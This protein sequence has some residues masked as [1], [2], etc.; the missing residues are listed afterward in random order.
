M[1]TVPWDQVRDVVDAVLALEPGQ[2]A[3]FLSQ[4]CPEPAVKR[5]VE[6]LLAAYDEGGDLLDQPAVFSPANPLIESE[7]K[8]WVG[9][10]ISSYQIVAEIGEGGMGAVYRAIRADDQY[11]QQVAIKVVRSGFPSSFTLGRFRA[12]RQILA[13]LEHPN[14]ARLLDGGAEAGLPYLV[15]EL[16]EG[17][18]IDQYCDRHRLTVTERLRLFRMACEAVQY[19]H[20]RLVVHRDLKPGNILVTSEGAPKL[21][22]FGIAKILDPGSFPH[23][24]DPTMTAMRMLTP[25]YASP[26]QVRGET[27]T[28]ATDVYS[29]GVVLYVLLTGRGPYPLKSHAPHELAQ[30][31]CDAEPEKPST[32]IGGG[33]N[34]EDDSE[35]GRPRLETASSRRGESPNRLRRRLRGDLDNIVLMALRKEPERRYA[36][37]EQLSEDI[38]RHLEGLP[39]IAYQDTLGYRSGKFIKRN[40]LAVTAVIVVVLS[41]V[42]G[43]AATVHEARVARAQRARAEQR[44]NDVRSL[45]NSLMFEIH[46]SIKD[47]PGSTPARK[48]LVE[49]ALRYLNSLA[50]ESGGDPALQRE[51]ANAYE[52]VGNV[53]GDPNGSNLGDTAGALD[54]FTKALRIRR[55]IAYAKS[56]DGR[57][58]LIALAA[59]YRE[60]CGVNARY[61]GNIGAGLDYC[62]KALD[63]AGK[64]NRIYSGNLRVTAELARVYDTIGRIY[65]EGSTV[66]N[67]GDS[68]AALENHRQELDLVRQLAKASP[69][70]PS[71]RQWLGTVDILTADDLFETGAV[72]EALPLYQEAMQTFE[73]L[74][75]DT[76]NPGYRRSLALSYQRMGDMLLTNGRYPQSLKYYRQ[77]LNEA[78]IIATADP[79]NMLFRRTLAASYATMGHAFW[80]A[81]QVSEGVASLRQGLVEIGE[82]TDKDSQTRNLEALIKIWVAGALERSGDLAGALNNYRQGRASFEAEWAADPRDVEGRLMLAGTQDRIAR[83]CIRQRRFGEALTEYRKALTL[84]EPLSTGTP[85]NLEALYTVVN[86][87]YGMGEVSIALAREAGVRN[88]KIKYWTEAR[89]WYQKSLDASGRIPN[90]RPITPNE[91]DSRS[92]KEIVARLSLCQSALARRS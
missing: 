47:L 86:V 41:L 49:R 64:L 44:F 63:L 69:S 74:A 8:S 28:T 52:R 25:E 73:L 78:T 72:P 40:K 24:P 39:I 71:L 92:P 58:D 68:Y 4:A 33:E 11:R 61:L 2:R 81:G 56:D 50:Q 70:D 80:R 31:I 55:N 7:A 37:V 30:A 82:P 91:F 48:L 75:R 14:I 9:R 35:K 3:D 60:I 16:V 6:S 77:Q 17:E 45:A 5:Y 38:R 85:P 89:T 12:E 46:D 62:G 53:Q 51:L 67:A 27:I 13:G 79:K 43:M 32:A 23:A 83:I 88:R 36:S 22:D 76:G 90:W 26:E 87:Y 21:L 15:M 57:D 1:N 66:G 19:A 20:R 84:T 65:G 42:V 29:L 18:P 34:A 59:S 54:S 10:R